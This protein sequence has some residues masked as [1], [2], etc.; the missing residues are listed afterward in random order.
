MNELYSEELINLLDAQKYLQAKLKLMN[1]L[2]KMLK[3]TNAH[4]DGGLKDKYTALLETIENDEE[5]LNLLD[6]IIPLC[7]ELEDTEN[8]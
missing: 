3:K 4:L 7:K 2:C 6:E 1:M 5:A 8:K